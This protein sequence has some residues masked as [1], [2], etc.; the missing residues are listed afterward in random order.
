MFVNGTPLL[1]TIIFQI[2]LITAL[3]TK[4]QRIKKMIEMTK[5]VKVHYSKLFFR[6]GEM[7]MDRNFGLSRG[8]LSLLNIGINAVAMD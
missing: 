2:K 8:E 1:I 6:I 4:Y 5:E 3:I 7:D